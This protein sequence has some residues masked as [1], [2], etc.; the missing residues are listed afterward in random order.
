MQ[1]HT[2][3]VRLPETLLTLTAGYRDEKIDAFMDLGAGI[4]DFD[5]SLRFG[6][7]RSDIDRDL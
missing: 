2:D 5:G 6:G 4:V 7:G 1:W 3:H